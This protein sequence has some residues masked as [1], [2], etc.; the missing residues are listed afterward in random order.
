[1]PS[2]L[3]RNGFVVHIDRAKKQYKLIA[4]GAITVLIFVGAFVALAIIY[5][6]KH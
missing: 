1:M 3:R 4:N 5:V 6:L 2:P